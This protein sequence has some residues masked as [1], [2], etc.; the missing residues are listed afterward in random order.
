MSVLVDMDISSSSVNSE[1][2]PSIAFKNLMVVLQQNNQH[3]VVGTNLHIHLTV[4]LSPSIL[5][6]SRS[7]TYRRSC[8]THAKI[9]Q[10]NTS[11]FPSKW[12]TQQKMGA[13][14][15]IF[16]AKMADTHELKASFSAFPSLI[17]SLE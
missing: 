13:R 15:L 5:Q 14:F 1:R 12:T 16:I 8:Q 3:T 11:N 6:P 17:S 9:P 7:G 2:R 10:D 4:S